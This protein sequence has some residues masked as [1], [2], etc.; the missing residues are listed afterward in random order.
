MDEYTSP[1]FSRSALLA[2]DLQRDF[3]ADVAGTTE[4]LP[5]VRR[6]THAFRQAG[7][8]IVH[9]VRLYL[10][11]GSNADL[12][13][14]TLRGKVNPHS[15][16]S[17]LAGEPAPGSELDPDLLLAGHAQEIGSDEHILYKP[18]WSAFFR[19]RLLEHLAERAVSTVVVAGCN[20]PNCPRSTLVDATER[21]LRTVAVR[22][23]LSGWTTDADREMTGMG[24]ACLDTSEVVAAIR[25]RV[26]SPV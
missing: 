26:I 24:I 11:D 6:L 3:V 10:S 5:A 21:D 1:E 20:Y 12:C 15:P 13:R 16:G 8:P 18:R 19:T 14:R 25:S 7:R 9:I 22:D 2:I 4:V 17:Q 23:A